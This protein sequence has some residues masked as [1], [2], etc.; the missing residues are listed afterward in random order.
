VR[1]HHNDSLGI[2]ET[3]YNTSAG[4]TPLTF[5]TGGTERMR[6]DSSGNVGIGTSS[7]TDKLS[8]GTSA[9][10]TQVKIQSGSGVNNCILHTNGTTDSWRV[11]MNLSLTNGS[12]EFYDDINNVTRLIL[13]SSGNLLVNRTTTT[14]SLGGDTPVVFANGAF[15]SFVGSYNAQYS[16]DRIN[17]NNGNYY[18]VNGSTVGVKLVNGATSWTTQSDE[19]KKD[20]IEPITS[21]V[22]KVLTLRAVIG[23]YKTDE[24]GVRR[25]F[26]IAQDVQSALPE[27]VDSGDSEDLG[28][29]YTE[30]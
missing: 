23:K 17:F 13:D 15:C 26:L 18:V 27:A 25:S 22:D 11:G 2:V 6:I 5:K 29:R 12:Y 24:D 8:V 28:V 19:R 3:T 30:I 7:P 20:I 10:G 9:G 21:A 14:T 4:Y 1:F 16:S